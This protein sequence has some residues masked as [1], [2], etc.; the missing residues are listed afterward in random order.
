MTKLDTINSSFPSTPLLLCT[1]AFAEAGKQKQGFQFE[2]NRWQQD[3]QIS[4]P[5]VRL[6]YLQVLPQKFTLYQKLAEQ[7]SLYC[8]LSVTLTMKEIILGCINCKIN[9]WNSTLG[10]LS[11][12]TMPWPVGHQWTGSWPCMC[13][14]GQTLIGL[15]STVGHDTSH[16]CCLWPNTNLQ[17][18]PWTAPWARI[19]M[20]LKPAQLCQMLKTTHI[21][22]LCSTKVL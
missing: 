14:I 9:K 19:N 15:F 3:Q 1:Q 21:I 2:W 6:T 12:R 13:P 22:I 11:K 16:E 8:W 20:K 4:F 5:P 10:F 7:W 17:H 18:I